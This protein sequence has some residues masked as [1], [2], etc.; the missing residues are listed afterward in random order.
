MNRKQIYAEQ[1]EH[2][3]LCDQA[4]ALGMPTSLED[5]RSPRTITGLRD[6]ILKA[7]A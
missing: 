4:R 2:Q 7:Q 6:A 3:Q 1:V 5:P